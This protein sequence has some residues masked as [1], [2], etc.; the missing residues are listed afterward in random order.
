MTVA[1]ALAAGMPS[2]G[3]GHVWTDQV[4]QPARPEF[5]RALGIPLTP[6]AEW[7]RAH[8]P[9]AAQVDGAAGRAG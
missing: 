9:P 8:V 5:A 7:A 4:G 2:W 6:F 3:A 1:E